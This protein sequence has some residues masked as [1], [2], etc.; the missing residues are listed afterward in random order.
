MAGTRTRAGRGSNQYVTRPAGTSLA[1]AGTAPTA[2]AVQA[3]DPDTD[4]YVPTA[5]IRRMQNPAAAFD[6]CK[7]ISAQV[8]AAAI[9]DGRDAR[10]VQLAWAPHY[11][12]ACTAWD[13][14]EPSFR[15][16]YLTVVDGGLYVDYTMRQFD[17]EASVPAVFATH[18][19]RE[20]YD[21]TD[22]LDEYLASI[23]LR[24]KW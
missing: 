19:W 5:V 18:E 2:A 8:T 16:H 4:R 24:A 17:P 12:D 1:R 3:P 23:P 7:A 10:W 22:R 14:I 6:N 15:L 20:E 11:P 21:V 9:A 13:D